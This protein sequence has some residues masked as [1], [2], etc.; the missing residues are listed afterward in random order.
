MRSPDPGAKAATFG[1]Y[2]MEA[3]VAISAVGRPWPRISGKKN[4]PTVGQPGRILCVPSDQLGAVTL[5]KAS[6]LRNH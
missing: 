5:I 4:G 3:S 1:L 2:R 6:R